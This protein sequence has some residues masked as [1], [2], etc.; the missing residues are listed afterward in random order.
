MQ[1]RTEKWYQQSYKT[2]GFHA[3]RKYPNEE[4]CRFMGRNFFKIS[5]NQRKDIRILETGC[6]SGGNIW[7]IAK[8]GFDAYGIDLSAEAIT[9]AEQMLKLYG[10]QC[11]LSVQNMCTMN[12][13]DN[14]FDSVVD[15]FS[16]YCLNKE[17]GAFYLKEVKRVLKPGGVFFSYF[18]SKASDTFTNKGDATFVDD[19]TI[20]SV[21]RAD[22]PY[23]GNNYN[24]RFLHPREYEQQLT[25]LD[26]S[27]AHSESLN[28]TYN[29]RNE[30]FNF[31]VIEAKKGA[32]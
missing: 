20:S 6:G 27:I 16:S 23:Y 26:F 14:Y 10:V 11:N 8:E 3:Q 24:V 17:G 18:P 21:L 15:I 32:I 9:W 31:V 12:F 7:M 30:N 19:D 2:N 22:S 4:L 28:K 1:Q 29:N 25:S 5:V 13:P